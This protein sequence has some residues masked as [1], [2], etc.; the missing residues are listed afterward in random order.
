MSAGSSSL[1]SALRT[2]PPPCSKSSF[3]P[4]PRFSNPSP[5]NFHA[6]GCTLSATILNGSWFKGP[7]ARRERV[8]SVVGA[9]GAETPCPA[10]ARSA[11][12]PPGRS[13]IFTFPL[14]S[15]V[16]RKAPGPATT[17]RSAF[18]GWP[19]RSDSDP[20]SFTPPASATMSSRSIPLGV[21][22][23]PALA[24]AGPYLA[25][26]P[27]TEKAPLS[28]SAPEITASVSLAGATDKAP[29]LRLASSAVRSARGALRAPETLPVPLAAPAISTGPASIGPLADQSK[30]IVSI[31]LASRAPLPAALSAAPSS[32][33]EAILSAPEP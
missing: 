31:C 30:S 4:G 16:V 12:A 32:F 29:K 20:S 22:R 8:C 23:N 25:V 14:T 17:V 6:T 1:K 28:P 18:D 10:R 26:G 3:P 11:T 21:K 33:A 7:E 9:P 19:L 13:T 24:L 5:E 2:P 15:P 27:A